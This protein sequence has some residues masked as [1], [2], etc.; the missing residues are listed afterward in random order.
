MCQCE[1]GTD[2]KNNKPLI[3]ALNSGLD[4]VNAGCVPGRPDRAIDP[5]DTQTITEGRG[6]QS[7]EPGQLEAA[8]AF[9][10]GYRQAMTLVTPTAKGKPGGSPHDVNAVDLLTA[11]PRGQPRIA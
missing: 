4:A 11:S 6:T 8:R 10:F 9:G 7:V 1:A 3:D 2:A 5:I